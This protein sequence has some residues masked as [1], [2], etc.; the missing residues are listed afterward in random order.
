MYKLVYLYQKL[1]IVKLCT[2]G[3][4]NYVKPTN[5]IVACNFKKALIFFHCYAPEFLQ[6]SAAHSV[7]ISLNQWI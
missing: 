6:N 2:T 7:L 5:Q 1:S 3:L 4:R